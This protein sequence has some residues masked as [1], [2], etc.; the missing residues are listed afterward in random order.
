MGVTRSQGK[1]PRP[2]ERGSVSETERNANVDAPELLR[3]ANRLLDDAQAILTRASSSGDD[4]LAL[5]A[6]RE[7]R[8]SLEVLMRVH[9]LLAPDSSV[10]VNVDARKLTATLDQLSLEQLK[11]LLPPA[12][13]GE[14]A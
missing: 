5:A 9:G 1:G 3:R 10:V 2:V 6:V 8:S 4:K 7:V 13:E 11:A 14:T 12:I